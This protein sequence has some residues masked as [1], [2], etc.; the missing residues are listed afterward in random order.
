MFD[1][2]VRAIIKLKVKLGDLNQY[3][4]LPETEQLIASTN[5]SLGG[6]SY[7]IK[8]PKYEKLILSIRHES[9][10][11]FT[12]SIEDIG[13]PSAYTLRCRSAPFATL[14]QSLRL[15]IE[16]TQPPIE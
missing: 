12:I 2:S 10:D 5:E 14:D 6:L 16:S 11:L 15:L 1:K 9:G 7:E 13:A 8:L 4:A 3:R